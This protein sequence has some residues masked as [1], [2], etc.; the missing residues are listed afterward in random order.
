MH[1]VGKSRCLEALRN[2]EQ[3]VKILIVTG[4]TKQGMNQELKEAGARDF[5]LK[6]FDTPQLLDKIRKIIDEDQF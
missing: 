6:P 2:M 3:N 5:I 4:H 1:R